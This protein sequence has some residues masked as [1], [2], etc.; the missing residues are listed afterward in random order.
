LFVDCKNSSDIVKKPC[1]CGVF[2]FVL[3]WNNLSSKQHSVMNDLYLNS[4][5]R[6]LSKSVASWYIFANDS[7]EASS[8]RLPIKL[9]LVG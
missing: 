6:W 2:A 7:S 9:I 8:K 3:E 4:G 1:H 5:G